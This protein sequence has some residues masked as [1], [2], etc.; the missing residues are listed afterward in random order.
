M[1]LVLIPL[2][3][4]DQKEAKLVS[5]NQIAIKA[6]HS[7]IRVVQQTENCTA[8]NL[9]NARATEI[10][11]GFTQRV[12]TDGLQTLLCWCLAEGETLPLV[13]KSNDADNSALICNPHECAECCLELLLQGLRCSDENSTASCREAV[14]NS[15]CV[16]TI[17]SMVA[18]TVSQRIQNLVCWNRLALRYIYTLPFICTAATV[19]VRII[20]HAFWTS[21]FACSSTL[22]TTSPRISD[23]EQRQKFADTQWAAMALCYNMVEWRSALQQFE[24]HRSNGPYPGSEVRI[25][26]PP[27]GQS[28]ELRVAIWARKPAAR[29]RFDFLR[30]SSNQ[31]RETVFRRRSHLATAKGTGGLDILLPATAIPLD[32]TELTEE[33]SIGLESGPIRFGTVTL[34]I[35]EYPTCV[36]DLNQLATAASDSY[37]AQFVGADGLRVLRDAIALASSVKHVTLHL[38]LHLQQH[39]WT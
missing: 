33:A 14:V 1:F 22:S 15:G 29:S 26:L 13:P 35:D 4:S 36:T 3:K 21:D 16:G 32:Q 28:A 20:Q 11:T 17:V 12:A 34:R 8:Q 7:D 18:H 27:I 31:K 9:I 2:S 37:T 38:H 24:I 6:E 23:T 25:E 5:S 30:N 10:A 19:R 39:Q